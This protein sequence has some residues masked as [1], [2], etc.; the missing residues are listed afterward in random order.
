MIQQ[1]RVIIKKTTG[2]DIKTAIEFNDILAKIFG[3]NQI[4]HRINCYCSKKIA[5]NFMVLRFVLIHFMSFYIISTILV[6]VS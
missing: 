1:T 4:F 5:Q 2:S 3:E 6:I